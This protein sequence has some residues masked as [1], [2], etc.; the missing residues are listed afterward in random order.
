MGVK[1]LWATAGTAALAAL[2]MAGMAGFRRER[3]EFMKEL[4]P[5]QREKLDEFQGGRWFGRG[6]R[7]RGPPA[8]Q[9]EQPQEPAEGRPD[10]AF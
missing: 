6:G 8:G 1:A 7:R 2:F 4:T 9:E 3:E 10:E 5:E